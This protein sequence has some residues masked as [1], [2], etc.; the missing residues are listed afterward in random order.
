MTQT[1]QQ[2]RSPLL[3]RRETYVAVTGAAYTAK[4]G[5]Q[6]V[7]VNRAGVVTVTLPT[8]EVRPGRIYTVKDEPGA[9]STNNITVATEGSE[10]I[11][12]SAT[13][14][15]ATDCEARSFYSDGSNWFIMP[16]TPNESPGLSNV[17]EDTTP[18]L[19]GNLDIQT[20][21]LVGNGGS[22]GIKISV[23]GEVTMAAQPAVAAYLPS[24]D[25]NKTGNG[26]TYTLGDPTDLTEI[27][28]QNGDLVNTTGVFTAPITGRYHVEACLKLDQGSSNIA[29]TLSIFSSNRTWS[30][31]DYQAGGAT[32][33]L[34]AQLSTDIDMDA[35]DTFTITLVITG[36]GSNIVDA[37]GGS[38]PLS[39]LSARLVA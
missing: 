7:G 26:A 39:F 24:S 12:G 14:V 8:A 5:D 13:K 18:Q 38:S 33:G 30:F 6:V 25:L 4:A 29:H 22:T 1:H 23:A 17:V 3:N 27:Y 9:A 36:E 16:V 10:T 2:H 31:R 37:L 15:M 35:A 28:D 20:N 19:G 11:D 32:N 21:I 34:S